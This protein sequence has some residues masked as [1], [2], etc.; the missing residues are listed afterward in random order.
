MLALFWES[1]WGRRTADAVAFNHA[2]AHTALAV[3]LKRSN[4][5]LRQQIAQLEAA[6]TE[7]DGHA[8]NAPIFNIG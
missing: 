6:M 3:S 2:T 4:M 5:K 7:I 1:S 8:A